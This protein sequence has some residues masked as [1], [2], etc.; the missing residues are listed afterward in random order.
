MRDSRCA[1]R[2]VLARRGLLAQLRAEAL[3]PLLE[4]APVA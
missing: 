4:M 1:M 2:G 3:D